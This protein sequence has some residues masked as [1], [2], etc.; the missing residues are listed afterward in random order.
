M[1]I[2]IADE[3]KAF[4][5]KKNSMVLTLSTFHTGSSCGG[6][7]LMMPEVG[8][9]VP[10][11][12]DHYNIIKVDDITVYI[13]NNLNITSEKIEFVAIKNL[14]ATTLDVRGVRIK[15]N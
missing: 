13:K 1:N 6:G 7:A 10:K 12:P 4:L 15:S 3:V 5:I 2:I 11:V 9:R 14:L 8:Y